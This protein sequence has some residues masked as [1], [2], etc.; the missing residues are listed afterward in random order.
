MNILILGFGHICKLHYLKWCLTHNSVETIFIYD[1]YLNQSYIENNF[2]SINKLKFLNKINLYGIFSEYKF[3]KVFILTNNTSHFQLADLALENNC[4]VLIEKPATTNFKDFIS[5][6]AKADLK[7]K[8]L[9]P[10]Y[11]QIYRSETEN[12]LINLK[13]HFKNNNNKIFDVVIEAG[14]TKG[15]PKH[16]LKD[17]FSKKKYSGGG[18][19]IDLGS[20]YLNLLFFALL[21][22]NQNFNFKNFKVLKQDKSTLNNEDIE[23]DFYAIMSNDSITVKLSLS[24]KKE[25]ENSILI[26][27]GLKKVKWPPNNINFSNLAFKNIIDK[28][29]SLK[30]REDQLIFKKSNYFKSVLITIKTIDQLYKSSI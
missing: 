16:S 4:D 1:P 22:T 26:N 21:E 19:L 3:E 24:Y 25:Y 2:K 8:I 13:N 23:K 17:G 11:H 30:E 18:V 15:I 9:F 12:F 28:F 5:L 7:N 10:A 29:L 20:H 14:N 27:D 6:K